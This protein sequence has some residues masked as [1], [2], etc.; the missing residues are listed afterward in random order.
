MTALLK[1][2][3]VV[4][5]A[6][7]VFAPGAG[8]VL[9]DFGAEVIH[10]EPPGIGDPLRMLHKMRPLPECEDSYCWL[11][12]SRNKKSIVVNLKN[13]EGHAVLVDLVRNADVFI[14]NYQHSVLKDLNL[15]YDLLS[16]ENPR[17]IY[18][19]ATSY[20][21]VG[22]EVEKPGYDATAWWARSGLMDAVRPDGG[23]L[24]I[25]T[26]G[27]G[28]HPSS[29]SLV[30]GIALALYARERNGQGTRISSSLMAN[31][32]WANSMLIQAALCGGKAYHPPT[33]LDTPNAMLNHYRTSDGRSLYLVLIKETTEFAHF[34]AAIG[35]PEL[36]R[37]PRFEQLE[38]RRANASA[39][40]G[41][42]AARFAEQTLTEW[43]EVLDQHKITFGIIATADE[44]PNDKQMQ[45]NGVFAKVEGQSGVRVVSS[46][47]ELG[48]Y[49]KV[50]PRP[51]PELG[52]N[53]VDLLRDLGYDDAKI[54]R[55]LDAGAVAAAA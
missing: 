48:G 24:A 35:K 20:G 1:D 3:R 31:G 14:T 10:V 36:A 11:M 55:L 39:L 33:Q 46:P 38:R 44:A 26:A 49:A 28:D 53:T 27:M 9:A 47:L 52:E 7:F 12:D 2:L 37:D 22:D 54:K 41:L 40:A 13:A 5:V 25:A 42:L 19:H 30:S 23:D 16:V 50:T 6:T 32:A 43:R 18:A 8:T 34:C 51:P 15:A 21:D 17:L 4:E 45:R 29:M